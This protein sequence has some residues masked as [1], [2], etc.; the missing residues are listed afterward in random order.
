MTKLLLYIVYINNGVNMRKRFKAKKRFKLK[1]LLLFLIIIFLIYFFYLISNVK[2]NISNKNI[3]N[4]ILYNIDIQYKNNNYINKIKSYIDNNIFNKP[5]YIL[6]T[7]LG[8]NIDN[9]TKEVSFL[10]NKS[11]SPLVYIYNSHQSETYTNQYLEDYNILPNVVNAANMLKEKLN[12]INIPTIVENNN[13]LE[14]MKQNKLDHSGSYIASRVF[15]E[16]TMNKYNTIKLYID[17]HR[18]AATHDT[19]YTN[20]NGLDCARVLFVIGL[21]YDTYQN[22]L[23]VVEKLNNIINEKYPTLSRGI[24]KKKGYGVNG[25]YNQDLSS[26]VILIEIG[27]NENN[28]VEVNNTLDLIANVIGEYLN[29][30]E[31]E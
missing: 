30:K 4:N 19:T 9:N 7:Q 17:L 27:G 8:N 21:E 23:K 14:Y 11:E 29:E 6:Y 16:N 10:Y 18:D 20:I 28:I 3:I 2:L 24:L 5:E 26:N 1:K 25:V 15:L 12:N 13:I 22:N 31:K